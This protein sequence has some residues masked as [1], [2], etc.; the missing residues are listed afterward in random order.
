MRVR[1][2][3]QAVHLIITEA[4]KARLRAVSDDCARPLKHIQLARVVLLLA[5]RLSILETSHQAAISK[6]AAWR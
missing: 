5:E 2:M 3:A 4:E 1:R 6:P